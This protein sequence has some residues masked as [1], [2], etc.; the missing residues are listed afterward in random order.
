[1][2]I[3]S[4][5]TFIKWSGNK[6]RYVKTILKHIPPETNT[7]IEPFVGSGAVFL[8][9]QPQR[10][11]IND[12]NKQLIGV[13]KSL[14]SPTKYK[15]L[16]KG[17]KGLGKRHMRHTKAENL[18][19]YRKLTTD[20]GEFKRIT[21]FTYLVLKNL[22][23]MGILLRGDKP[24]F[25]GFDMSFH[26][27]KVPHVYSSKFTENLKNVSTYLQNTKGHIYN[28]DYKSILKRAK[29]GDF[30]FLDPPYIEEHKYDFQYNLGEKLDQGFL[31]DLKS[32][33]TKLDKRGVRWLMTQADTKN[34]RETFK[35]YKIVP[36]R[37]YR[38]KTKQYKNELLIR[39]Y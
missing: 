25:R 28:K 37:V 9:V 29:R 5:K 34:V 11:I 16:L 18:K 19:Y 24:Y 4:M 3:V 35:S 7:Y 21:P 39:N 8:K 15:T 14:T 33:V 12:L 17:I 2:N 1:M 26:L 38:N 31:Q 6:S 13:W 30:C 36:F 27:Q 22:V 32:E 23:Y 10:W 20:E